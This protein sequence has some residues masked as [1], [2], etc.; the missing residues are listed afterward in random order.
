MDVLP[1]LIGCGVSPRDIVIVR[2]K[3]VDIPGYEAIKC[4]TSI[5]ELPEDFIA[6]SLLLCCLPTGEVFQMLSTILAEGKPASILVDTPISLIQ[7]ELK[8]LEWLYQIE[9]GVLEDSVLI[10]WLE[11]IKDSKP[12]VVFIK[13]GLYYYHGTALISRVANR[14]LLRISPWSLS[15]SFPWIF[16]DSRFRTFIMWGTKNSE[17]AGG[18]VFTTFGRVVRDTNFVSTRT[19]EHTKSSIAENMQSIGIDY[20][21]AQNSPLGSMDEWK[22]IGLLLGL[23]KLILSKEMAFPSID[24]ALVFER[25]SC[26][27]QSHLFIPQILQKIRGAISSLPGGKL[28]IRG[29]RF[30]REP[31]N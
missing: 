10:P 7:S 22:R 6:G 27:D 2:K 25:L 5:S 12:L 23:R 11:D 26:W 15:D 17:K 14:K 21:L 1:A 18:F 4:F 29:I 24:E 8:S 28:F 3:P 13:H 30:I 16:L 20:S 31:R 19:S 9:I